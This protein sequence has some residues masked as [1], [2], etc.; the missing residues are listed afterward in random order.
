MTRENTALDLEGLIS[1]KG[2]ID[3]ELWQNNCRNNY[4]DAIHAVEALGKTNEW[5]NL[6]R[7]IARK[8]EGCLCPVCYA[9]AGEERELSIDMAFPPA[10]PWV[11]D[12]EDPLEDMGLCM[13]CKE[14]GHK[15]YVEFRKGSEEDFAEVEKNLETAR[16]AQKK[17]RKKRRK[18]RKNRRR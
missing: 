9:D 6:A 16:N 15:T 2:D 18:T 14:C 13:S 3:R 1:E 7:S 8:S 10:H 11:Y 5:R 17:R 12:P 4:D